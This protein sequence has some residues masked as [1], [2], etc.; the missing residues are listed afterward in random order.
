MIAMQIYL[1]NM[2]IILIG[3]INVKIDLINTKIIFIFKLVKVVLR[4]AKG[5]TQYGRN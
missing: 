3:L 4:G 2:Q 5:A 1:I